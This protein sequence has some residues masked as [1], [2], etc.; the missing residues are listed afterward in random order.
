[1]TEDRVIKRRKRTPT[2]KQTR[3]ANLLAAGQHT[4]VEAYCLSYATDS[5]TQTT[6]RN[7][8]SK[9]ASNPV[10]SA[11]VQT[12]KLRLTNIA[13]Q[14]ERQKSIQT[15]SDT[16][17][18]LSRLRTWL[19]NPPDSPLQLRA[20]EILAR[21]IGLNGSTIEIKQEQSSSDLLQSINAILLNAD[22]DAGSDSDPIH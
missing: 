6:R 13:A 18:V 17:R 1:M 20:S 14:V 15:V 16:E 12:E 21:A 19:D 11:M 4:L 7:E 5:M 2:A 10:I 9:L 8:A 22:P 3:F